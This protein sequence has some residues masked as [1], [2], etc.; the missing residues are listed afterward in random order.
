[1]ANELVFIVD[2][3]SFY[4]EELTQWLK[5]EGFQTKIFQK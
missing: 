2:Q 5:E 4:N 1:M 3:D